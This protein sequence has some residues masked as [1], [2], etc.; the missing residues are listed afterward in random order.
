[1]RGT[2]ARHAVPPLLV[3]G[4]GGGGGAGQGVFPLPGLSTG[5]SEGGPEGELIIPTATEDVP[6]SVVQGLW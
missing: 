4:V 3:R 5:A 1:M 2:D 6:N